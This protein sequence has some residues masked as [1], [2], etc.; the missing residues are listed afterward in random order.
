M[1][2]VVDYAMGNV[3]SAEKVFRKLGVAVAVSRDPAV[4]AQA[5][6]IVLPGVGAFGAGMQRL[7]DFGLIPMLQTKV[8]KEKL[9]FLGIC[10]GMQLLAEVGHEYG[11]HEGLG[12]IKGR[13]QKLA[14]TQRLPHIGWNDITIAQDDVLLKDLPDLNAYFV[15]SYHLQCD[16]PGVVTSTCTYGER[17]VATIHKENIFGTQFHP[18][19]SQLL[20]IQVI[21]NFLTYA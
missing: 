20:G 3:A 6:H 10:L 14:Q 2:V 8:L 9:P 4:F 15:H 13:V 7:K 12:W 18:E 11:V 19:K 21:K 1:V 16:E 5:T 17:F